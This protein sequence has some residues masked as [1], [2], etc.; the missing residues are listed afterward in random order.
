MMHLACVLNGQLITA[1]IDEQHRE[2][3]VGRHV[4]CTMVVKNPKISRR[5][6]Q[7]KWTPDGVTIKDLGSSGGTH[8]GDRKIGRARIKPGDR[9]QLADI[10]LELKEGPA[11]K[12]DAHAQPTVAVGDESVAATAST[13]SW[14]LH[15]CDEEGQD[16]VCTLKDGSDPV[17]LGRKADCNIRLINPTV[18]RHHC[19]VSLANGQLVAKDL[20][21]SN[22]TF[23]NGNK[24]ESGK[25]KDGDVLECGTAEVKIK[26]I[27]ASVVEEVSSGDTW[28][29]EAFEEEM[30]PPNWFLV[31]TDDE[32]RITTVEMAMKVRVLAIG[33]DKSCEICIKDRGMEGEHIEMNW[34]YGVLVVRDLGTAVGTTLNGRKIDEVVLRNGDVITCGDFQVHIVRGSSGEVSRASTGTRSHDADFWAPILSRHEDGLSMT[35]VDTDPYDEKRKRELTIWGD[36][37]ASLE[38]ITQGEKESLDARVSGPLLDALFDALVRAGFPDVSTT[39]LDDGED[40]AEL[41]L[42]LDSEASN[43]TLNRRVLERSSVYKEV[44]HLLDAILAQARG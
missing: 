39:L 15:Y 16:Q 23:I 33:E 9:I 43:V 30:G 1:P 21:S 44:A 17:T 18:G 31:Y 10:T 4:D 6:C 29:D 5:H 32:R 42:Y 38:L 40:P 7:V 27:A 19:Q 25:L 22:G 26:A 24:I 34:E 13:G 2:V 37:E 14:E 11:P 35:Y 41:E 20:K 8:V 28:S 12:P 36:G 3:V